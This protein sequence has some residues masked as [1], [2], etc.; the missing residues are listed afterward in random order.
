VTSL[1]A[2][3]SPPSRSTV[4]GEILRY[5]VEHPDAKDTIDGILRWWIPKGRAEHKKEDVEHA[6]NELVAKGWIV[7][8]ETTPSHAVY[9]VDQH[10]L[11]QIGNFLTSETIGNPRE[12]NR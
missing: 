5:L 8:R 7:K 6:I 12:E 3:G 1:G 2:E 11:E 9:G 10:Q 4:I